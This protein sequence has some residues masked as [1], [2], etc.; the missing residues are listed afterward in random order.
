MEN[1]NKPAFTPEV[2]KDI[3][4]SYNGKLYVIRHEFGDKFIES[5]HFYCLT[6]E[7]MKQWKEC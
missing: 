6:E 5:C 7:M 4:L 1:S 2:I 3:Y